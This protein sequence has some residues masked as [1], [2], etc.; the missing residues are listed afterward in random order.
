[1]NRLPGSGI[2][3]AERRVENEPPPPGGNWNRLYW[4]VI[5]FL[6]VQIIAYWL[7]TRAFS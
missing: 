2:Q 1:M 6:V 7:F 4:F 3:E 5:G